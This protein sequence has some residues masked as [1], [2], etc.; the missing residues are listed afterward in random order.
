VRGPEF[1]G[2]ELD[3][4]LCGEMERYASAIAHP[5]PPCDP[6]RIGRSFRR[7]LARPDADDQQPQSNYPTP[8]GGGGHTDVDTIPNWPAATLGAGSAKWLLPLAIALFILAAVT[9]ALEENRMKTS[10]R[11]LSSA[12]R[13]GVVIT[14]G[15]R[16]K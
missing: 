2:R 15:T 13:L 9:D 4:R 7:R 8:A 12:R 16:Y 14:H 3:G 1:V 6:S 11:L 5:P 10:A